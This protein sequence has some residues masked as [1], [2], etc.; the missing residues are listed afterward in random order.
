MCWFGSSKG[1][2]KATL[3]NKNQCVEE[4]ELVYND[5]VNILY[6]NTTGTKGGTESLKNFLKYL[7]ESKH[8]NV[9][10]EATQ[11]IDNYVGTIKENYSVGG[12]YMTF[13]DLIDKIVDE[14]VDEVIAE[15]NE[16]IAE[17]DETIA[18]KDETIAEKDAEI[19]E[20]KAQLAKLQNK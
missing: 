6:F 18:E 15:K 8:T 10:D 14:A 12:N 5:G 19:E 3:Y 20:L 4:S 17:K 11:E 9:V 1:C 13:G 2:Y 7:E 16:T